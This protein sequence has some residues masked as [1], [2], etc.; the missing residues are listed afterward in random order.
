MITGRCHCGD[1]AFEIDG[2]IP[3]ELTRCTCSLCSKRGR[4]YAYYEPTAFRRLF[5]KDSAGE[6]TYFWKTKLVA[7]N[8][9]AR[10]GCD[11]YADSPVFVPEEDFKAGKRRIAV[12][13]RLF[14][15]F[16]AASHPVTV[17][18]GQNLW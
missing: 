10:C 18:D 11:I 2:D 13:A 5:P 17:I 12:N 9:C 3:D 14:D 6:S 7:N 1:I 15:D 16:D 4:L 8:F